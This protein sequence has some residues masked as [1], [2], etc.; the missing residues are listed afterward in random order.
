MLIIY[1]RS[2]F[3]EQLACAFFPLVLLG[4]L[5]LAGY[6]DSD[7]PLS[8]RIVLFAVPFA[9]VW[10]SNAPAGVIT[11]YSVALLFTW[12]TVT[13]GEERIALRGIA[14]LA[15]GFGLTSF[16][17]IPAAYEQRWVNIEQALSSGLLPVQ[18]FLFTEINDP[19]HT[20]F[21]WIASICALVLILLVGLMALASAKFTK[22]R[23]KLDIK[24]DSNE[25][26]P[27]SSSSAPPQRS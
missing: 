20:W 26:G 1:I 2:D 9:A 23:L 25:S 12:A 14:G 16:Y 10:L 4:A 24:I 27:S 17:L 21:N 7:K 18:N 13:Q 8:S 11:T 5:R 3:A 19:E 22:R 6:L 15:L